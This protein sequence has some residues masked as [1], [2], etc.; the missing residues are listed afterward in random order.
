MMLV[1]R[2]LERLLLRPVEL[3][4]EEVDSRAEDGPEVTREEGDEPPV[5]VG[6]EDLS[7]PASHR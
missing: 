5:T 3:D 2:M 6:C 7:P 4:K 1:L